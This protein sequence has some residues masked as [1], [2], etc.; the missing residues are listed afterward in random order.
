MKVGIVT[1]HDSSNLGSYLQALGMQEI[2]KQNGDT[3]YI[4]RTRS[5]FTTLCLFLGY[6]NAPSVRSLKGLVRFV[7]S[8]VCHAKR[9]LERFRKYKEYKKDW[10]KFE[11][12]ISVNQA[13]KKHLD[14]ILLGSDEIW[15][16]WQPAFQNPFLYGVGIDANKKYAYAVSAGFMKEDGWDSFPQ[17][18]D[19]M[20]RLNAILVRDNYT[21][22]LLQRKG[23]LV[24][25]KICDPTLQIDIRKYMKSDYDAALSVKPYIAVYSYGVDEKNIMLIKNF[26]RKHMLKTVAISLPQPWCDEYINCSPLEFGAVLS[27]ASFVYTSTFHGTIFSTLYHTQFVVNPFSQKVTDVLEVLGLSDLIVPTDC[28]DECFEKLITKKRDYHV[29]EEKILKVRQE[30]QRMYKKYIHQESK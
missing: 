23:I 3:P 30:S 4:I 1:V 18:I 28:T 5:V 21:E 22:H 11:K 12:I 27:N 15:N 9:S 2:V 29:V 26:A 16:A 13:N 17:L 10:S 19:G 14:V 7:V 24:S 25:E 6:N 8:S 20:R